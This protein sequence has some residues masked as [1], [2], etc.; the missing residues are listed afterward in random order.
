VSE[1]AAK[2]IDREDLALRVAEAPQLAQGLAPD[3]KFVGLVLPLPLP[4]SSVDALD[5]AI[6]ANPL[7]QPLLGS[8]AQELSWQSAMAELLALVRVEGIAAAA[9]PATAGASAAALELLLV[10]ST[11]ELGIEAGLQPDPTPHGTALKPETP[12]FVDAAFGNVDA[13][14][15]SLQDKDLFG[16]ES[17]PSGTEF[18]AAGLPFEGSEGLDFDLFGGRGPGQSL[19]SISKIDNPIVDPGTLVPTNGGVGGTSASISNS[20]SPS[21]ENGILGYIALDK[22][23]ATMKLDLDA[24][25]KNVDDANSLTVR[26]DGDDQ[27]VLVGDWVLVSEDPVKSV[28]VY[29]YAD[30]PVSVVADNVEVV[31]A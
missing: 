13:S 17:R 2:Q 23:A 27:L 22:G 1:E 31:L 7:S 4:E 16:L 15:L 5:S 8:L 19:I 29:A 20:G 26:G 11:S 25:L 3:A 9:G 18:R 14:V 24:A 6:A 28:S 12:G 21:L 30:Q 10:S